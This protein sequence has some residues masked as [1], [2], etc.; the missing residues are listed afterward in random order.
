MDEPRTGGGLRS[1]RRGFGSDD[2][3][4]SARRPGRQYSSYGEDMMLVLFLICILATLV[5]VHRAACYRQIQDARRNTPLRHILP[6]PEDRP[7]PY[8]NRYPDSVDGPSS[9]VHSSSGP[10]PLTESPPPTYEEALARHATAQDT[11]EEQPAQTDQLPS[12]IELEPRGEA[13]E[14]VQIG[15]NIVPNQNPP[16]VS[17]G[18]TEDTNPDIQHTISAL[19]TSPQ[20]SSVEDQVMRSEEDVKKD[21]EVIIHKEVANVKDNNTCVVDIE[22]ENISAI[23]ETDVLI[24]NDARNKIQVGAKG[25]DE[26]N[27]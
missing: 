12:G 25:D 10:K 15:T 21:E 13:S 8:I 5:T 4:F 27:A 9:I 23:D 22:N 2:Y 26:V 6:I 17:S 19:V 11:L 16:V 3:Y 7:P 20:L 14:N 1:S 18:G 24:V